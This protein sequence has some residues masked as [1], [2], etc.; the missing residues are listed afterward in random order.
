M[1]YVLCLFLI[2]LVDNQKFL[3]IKMHMNDTKRCIRELDDSLYL[4]IKP[5][6]RLIIVTKYEPI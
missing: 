1:V 2:N 4:N 3:K 5:K 6:I